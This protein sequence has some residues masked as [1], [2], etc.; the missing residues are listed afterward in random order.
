MLAASGSS[1]A[2]TVGACQG[3]SHFIRFFVARSSFVSPLKHS[4]GR[5]PQLRAS[6]LHLDTAHSGGVLPEKPLPGERTR[7]LSHPVPG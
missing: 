5:K 7:M 2:A 3:I 6:L 4:A 1:P